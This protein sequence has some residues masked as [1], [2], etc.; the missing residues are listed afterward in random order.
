M[1]IALLIQAGRADDK[2]A[3][4]SAVADAVADPAV[5]RLVVEPRVNERFAPTVAHENDL[6]LCHVVASL[7]VTERLDVEVAYVSA[8]ATPATR[9]YRLP[10]GPAARELAE[11]GT[12][13]AVPLIRDDTAS[14]IFGSARHLGAEGAKL[15]GET[16]V[17]NERLFDGEVRSILIEPTLEAPGLRAQVERMLLPGKW[18]KGRACQ[19]GG[20]NIVVEREGVVNPRVLKRSTFYRHVTDLLLVRP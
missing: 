18:F 20:T 12:A 7:M 4:R 8:E 19:T 1:S 16:Y 14:V 11:H 15:H 13:T 3:I 9:R 6:F 10:H 5:S 17:D 2:K